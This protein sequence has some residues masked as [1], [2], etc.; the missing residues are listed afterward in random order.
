MSIHVEGD[1]GTDNGGSIVN[2]EEYQVWRRRELANMIWR[3]DSGG[4]PP[5][6]LKSPF[7]KAEADWQ[8]TH[9]DPPPPDQ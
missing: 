3:I 7:T 5:L 1:F 4:V 2:E 9:L 6:T 8:S